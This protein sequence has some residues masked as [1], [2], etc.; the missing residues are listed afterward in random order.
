MR[1]GPAPRDA[2]GSAMPAGAGRVRLD[3]VGVEEDRAE[4]LLELDGLVRR[5]RGER[6]HRDGVVLAREPA[7]PTSFEPEVH[8]EIPALVA[9]STVLAAHDDVQQAGRAGHAALGDE[10]D[11]RLEDE[12][13]DGWVDAGGT[14]GD[15]R[16]EDRREQGPLGEDE[17]DRPED[18][19]VH[20]DV[21]EDHLQVDDD[22][23]D[24]HRAR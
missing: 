2:G 17:V 23:R 10:L 18:P 7:T 5:G 11:E 12:V 4:P 20:R 16:R 24:R 15:R 1:E 9:G 8:D 3:P 14:S 6:R 21:R 22:R 13:A 19:L